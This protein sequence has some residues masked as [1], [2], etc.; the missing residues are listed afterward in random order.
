VMEAFTYAQKE[1]V[2][3]YEGEKK[4]LTE[5]AVVSD[6]TLARTLSFGGAAGSTDPRIMALVAE[7]YALESKVAELR[8]KKASMDSTAYATELERLLLAIAE[9]SQAIRSS[10]GTP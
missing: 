1:V 5:H 8:A 2:R 9:K 7:R 4:L 6:S 3:A 10:G